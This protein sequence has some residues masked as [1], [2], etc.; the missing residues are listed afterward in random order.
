MATAAFLGGWVVV[1]GCLLAWLFGLLGGG[2]MGPLGY[3]IERFGIAAPASILAG[4][5]VAA[6]RAR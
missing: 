4:A 2:A 6:Y 1:G 3:V 5:F